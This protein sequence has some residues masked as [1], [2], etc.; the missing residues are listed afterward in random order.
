M[1][2][3]RSHRV[4]DLLLEF[5]ARLLVSEMEDPRLRAVTLTGINV[6]RDLKHATVYFNVRKDECVI[7]VAMKGLKQA[8]GYMRTKIGR[9]LG[10]R[11]VPTI[12]WEFDETPDRAQRIDEL[13][14]NSD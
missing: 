2:Y 12:A 6:R 8:T 4:G 14:R 10:L 5:L 11:F 1:N 7:E 9:E 13:L 3:N